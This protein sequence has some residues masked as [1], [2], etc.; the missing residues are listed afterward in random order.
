MS[1][2]LYLMPLFLLY[3]TVFELEM[4]FQIILGHPRISFHA[5]LYSHPVQRHISIPLS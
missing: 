5:I 3:R 2:Y 4:T 1:D